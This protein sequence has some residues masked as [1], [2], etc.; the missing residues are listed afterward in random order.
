MHEVS[1]VTSLVDAVIGELS[2]YKLEK[3]NAVF[4]MIGDLTNLGDEQMQFAYEIVTRGTILEGSELVI[5]HIPVEVSCASCGY[6]GPVR[7]LTDPDYD[8]HSIPVLSCP[9]CG[10][11]ITV[12]RGMECTVKC[13]DIE[14]VDG[15]CS[16]T[17]TRRLRRRSSTASGRWTWMCASCTSAGPIRTRSSGSAWRRCSTTWA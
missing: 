11:D 8:T 3:V 13:M 9:E 7:M 14:E 17:G 6:E 2:S 5:E 4:V 1:V 15:R 12:V 10:G 16:S